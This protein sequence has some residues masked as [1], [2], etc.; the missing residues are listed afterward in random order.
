[1]GWCAFNN[2]FSPIFQ[3]DKTVLLAMPAARPCSYYT[4]G[5]QRGYNLV[6]T[7]VDTAHLSINWQ[8]GLVGI[9]LNATAV[10]TFVTAHL[11]F[12]P[13]MVEQAIAQR[14]RN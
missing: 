9:C 11:S 10:V 4:T 14:T 7:P 8:T 3:C 1:M 2:Q 12:L 5:I 6:N 13:A